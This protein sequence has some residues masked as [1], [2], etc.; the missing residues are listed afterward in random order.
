VIAGVRSRSISAGVR[1]RQEASLRSGQQGYD[2]TLF[3]SRSQRHL[4]G[5]REALEPAIYRKTTW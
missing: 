4:R 3:L 1:C 2:I 5:D